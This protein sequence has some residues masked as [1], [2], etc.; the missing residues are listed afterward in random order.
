MEAEEGYRVAVSL[1]QVEA[2]LYN[3]NTPY[4]CSEETTLQYM[5]TFNVQKRKG[6]ECCDCMHPLAN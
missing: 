3:T 6:I 5:C 4:E 1:A 2:V